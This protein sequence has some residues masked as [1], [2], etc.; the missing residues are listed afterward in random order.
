MK[1][2]EV[3]AATN[4]PDV[5]SLAGWSIDGTGI[6]RLR[7]GAVGGEILAIIDADTQPTVVLSRNVPAS[8]GVF[9]Q[10]VGTLVN[11]VLYYD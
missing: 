11:C 1:S 6:T 10:V 9:V 5:G 8:T 4:Y 7:A 2:R 3:A